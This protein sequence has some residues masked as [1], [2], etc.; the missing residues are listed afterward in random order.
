MAFR[1][2][3]TRPTELGVCVAGGPG[4]STGCCRTRKLDQP[5]ER[6][7]GNRQ[8]SSTANKTRAGVVF[9]SVGILNLFLIA[10]PLCCPHHLFL[11]L[12]AILVLTVTQGPRP[13]FFHSLPFSS[14][15]IAPFPD[16][17]LATFQTP[18]RCTRVPLPLTDS[19]LSGTMLCL[20]PS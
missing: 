4:P 7:H 11:N 5:G 9:V 13:V 3:N 12:D 10:Y 16:L 20:F 8:A 6:P 1:L 17:L 14:L 15:E 19:V 2:G 18:P